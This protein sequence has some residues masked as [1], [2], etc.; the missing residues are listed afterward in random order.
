MAGGHGGVSP[1]AF[2][3]LHHVLSPAQCPGLPVIFASSPE[4]PGRIVRT[5][6][7]TDLCFSGFQHCCLFD[8]LSLK[9][10]LFLSF[11]H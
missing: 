6:R 10:V 1:N 3:S 11:L 2:C 5:S 7:S 4:L 8:W 9:E